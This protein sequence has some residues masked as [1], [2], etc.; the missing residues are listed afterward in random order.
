MGCQST[1]LGESYFSCLSLTPIVDLVVPKM[2]HVSGRGGANFQIDSNF[3][4]K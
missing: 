4:L 1:T 2:E 3:Y